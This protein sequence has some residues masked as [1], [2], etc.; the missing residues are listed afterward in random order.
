[1]KRLE[2]LLYALLNNKAHNQ[3]TLVSHDQVQRIAIV[4][5]NA[6]IGNMYF[7]IPFI[8]QTRALYPN[9]EITLV[10]KQ[11]WQGEVFDGLKV[12][13]F[14]YTQFSFK[15]LLT[16]FKEIRSL[17][18]QV[19][20]LVVVPSNSVE[21]SMICAMLNAKNKV[22]SPNENRNLCYTHT[23]SKSDQRNH[24]AYTNLYLLTELGNTL[25]EP[26]SHHIVLKPHEVEFGLEKKREFAAEGTLSIA[27]FRGARGSKQLSESTWQDIIEQFEQASAVPIQWVEVLSPDIT[28]PLP[29]AMHTIFQKDMRLLASALKQ[30]DGFICCDTGP[31]HLADA[32]GA[33]CVGLYTATSAITF[34]V[35]GDKGASVELDSLNAS[36]A[37]AKI[38]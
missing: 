30:L 35:L 17:K 38:L 16:Y 10:L 20:D 18:K 25:I 19:F 22:S 21:D 27:Y 1:M 24:A 36:Q 29:S 15:G 33:K 34:G 13:H 8:T 28:A 5:N 4:R 6:R 37:L 12:D 31:L 23:F 9:A 26:I 32:A 11:S 14:S 2:V 3:S 7:L